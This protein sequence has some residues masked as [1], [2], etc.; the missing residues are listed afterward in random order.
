MVATIST[1]MILAAGLGTRMRPLTNDRP[2]ALVEV[3]GR[4]L[5]DWAIQR[6]IAGGVTKIVINVHHYADDLEAHIQ[7]TAER[8]AAEGTPVE[9]LISDERDALL[10]TGG[11]LVKAQP[12][13]GDLFFSQNCDA[14]W[15]E[16]TKNAFKR[17]ARHWDG[18]KMDALLLL[19]PSVLT[20]GF[21][22]PGDF[23]MDASGRL[24]RR[25]EKAIAP[26]VFS[27]AQVMH[28]RLLKEAPDGKF[29]LNVCF[30]RALKA[31]RLFGLRH[32]SLWMHVGTP[33]SILEAEAALALY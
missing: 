30:D 2:K 22:G 17:L 24:V 23:F 8:L 3:D 20:T 26:Y 16:G 10:E 27:G 28:Q 19:A 15:L 12:L 14:M 6:Y 5:I 13:M 4:P 32:E 7:E 31:G 29:S 25:G 11:G 9:I 21:S 33:D 18:D 1:G